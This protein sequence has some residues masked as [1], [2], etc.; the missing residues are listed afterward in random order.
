[1]TP[2]DA[3]RRDRRVLPRPTATPPAARAQLDLYRSGDFSKIEPY[4]GKLAELGVPTLIIWGVEDEFAPVAGAYRFQK[5]IPG[6]RLVVLDHAG[7]FLMEDEPE[8]VGKEM[9][10]FLGVAS[11]AHPWR[12]LVRSSAN[13]LKLDMPPKVL[14]YSP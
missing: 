3:G 10:S 7:H 4:R 12:G 5:E 14:P 11:D 6:S 8:R 2:V 9:R 13:H 1:M